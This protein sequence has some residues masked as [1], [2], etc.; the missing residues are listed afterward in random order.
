M[1]AHVLQSV[2][3]VVQP[4]VVSLAFGLIFLRN[5]PLIK[6]DKTQPIYLNTYDDDDDDFL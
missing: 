5:K 1:L 3:A 2:H 6:W 4:F